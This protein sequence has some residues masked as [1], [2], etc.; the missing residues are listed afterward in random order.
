MT[1]VMK[2][3]ETGAWVAK[4]TVA[5][6]LLCVVILPILS[7]LTQIKPADILDVV[8]GPNFGSALW[9]SLRYTAIATLIVVFLAYLMALCTTRV[10]IKGKRIWNV[11]LILPMLIPSISHGMALL[12][13]FGQNGIAKNLLGHTFPVYGG[14]GIVLG[15]VMYA[16]PVAYIMLADV[17]R[18]EDMSVYEAAEVLGIGKFRTFLRVSL[19]Y[20]KK[21]LIA[22]A[23]STFA[24]VVTDYGVPLMV[25]GTGNYTVSTLMYQAAID[26]QKFGRGAVYGL[27]LLLPAIVAFV[28]DLLGKERGTGA[29]VKKA[30]EGSN[31]LL[32]KILAYAMCVG[33]SLFALMPI[34][35]F[36]FLAI[37]K[38]YP[39]DLSLTADHFAYIF[40]GQGATYLTN[41]LVIALIT[42]SVGTAI[43]FITAYF[44][45]RMRSP[46]SRGLHLLAISSMAIPGMVLGISYVMTF[47]STP[48]YGTLVL[49]VMVNTA[50]FISSPYLMMYNSLGKMNQNLEAVGQT[51]GIGRVRMLWRVFL[52]QSV[53]T[54]AEMFSYLFVNSMMTISAVSFLANSTNKPI[55]L[56]ISQFN[57]HNNEYVAVVSILILV[58]NILIKLAVEQIKAISARRK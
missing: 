50:H 3:R 56:M 21:P 40:R 19:P 6:V 12:I 33:M 27:I 45:A 25:A 52:P 24:M 15:S 22:A 39:I 51:L 37:V 36:V 38:K 35:V 46:L 57:E 5:A 31:K 28:M 16:L 30:H 2:K 7:M 4:W 44:S 18:Y 48:L 42:A 47:A 29:Y 53:G 14:T 13:L 8:K 9:N 17:L 49:L 34:A 41:S 1:G 54:L 11:I 10:R 58:V 23:F 32:H 55:S 26:Q 43:G 20:L